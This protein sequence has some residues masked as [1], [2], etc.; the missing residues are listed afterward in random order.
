MVKRQRVSRADTRPRQLQD[1]PGP[2]QLWHQLCR[3]G[4]IR[5]S[6]NAMEPLSGL[7]K[8]RKA[9][10]SQ[11]TVCC[12]SAMIVGLLGGRGMLAISVSAVESPSFNLTRTRQ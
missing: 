6:R 7:P 12:N 5:P 3:L 4:E 11:R 9:S 1:V 8:L 2:V 10:R